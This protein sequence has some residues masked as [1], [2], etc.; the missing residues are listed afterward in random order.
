MDK[1]KP[2]P[3]ALREYPD[4]ALQSL[5]F[6]LVMRGVAYVFLV[7]TIWQSV[8]PNSNALGY[9][10]TALCIIDLQRRANANRKLKEAD[11]ERYRAELSARK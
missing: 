10:G 8:A 9:V 6:R 11:A 4:P 3:A 1:P 5:D 2:N 7:S